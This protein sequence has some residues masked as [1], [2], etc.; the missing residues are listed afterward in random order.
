M[1]SPSV[2]RSALVFLGVLLTLAPPASAQVLPHARTYD[3][4]VC[5][6]DT[7]QLL[8]FIDTD[9]NGTITE[10]NGFQVAFDA[11]VAGSVALQSPCSIA[12]DRSG[13]QYTSD[14][15]ADLVMRTLDQ[16]GDGDA[17][18]AGEWSVFIDNSNL[19]GVLFSSAL[20]IRAD[21]QGG[22]VGINSSGGSQP[23]D[24]V[25][26]AFDI[27]QDGDAMDLAE[28]TIVYDSVAGA[29]N[30]AV[31]FGLCVEPS[32]G[33]LLVAD[34][35]P[36]VVYRL[37]DANSDGDYY[38]AG[39]ATIA[40]NSPVGSP[41]IKN[42]NTVQFAPDGALFLNDATS[43]FILRGVDGNADGDWNDVG[44]MAIFADKTG[45]T[46]GVPANHFGIEIDE[47]GRVFAVEN[48]TT[49]GDLVVRYADLNGD[50]DAQDAGEVI[51]VYE[52]GVGPGTVSTLRNIALVPAPR[53]E[54][55]AGTSTSS[56][57]LLQLEVH[58]F[59]SQPYQLLFGFVPLGM[60]ASVAPYG[61]LSYVPFA[62]LW[63]ASIP[64]G[65]IDS[66]SFSIPAGL[67]TPFTIHFSAAV[68]G[69]FRTYL[70]NE[71][72]ISF[73]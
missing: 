68:G 56:P 34:V 41:A 14:F 55:P 63:S 32:T 4:A 35:N 18:D 9:Q 36:D 71:Q 27:N 24:F 42:V 64:V 8:R 53:L 46:I 52:G 59:E 13:W 20:V 30:I 22:I 54:A 60:N 58:G 51:K 21:A 61:Y 48:S 62:T 2:A 49:V 15:S 33:D 44:E 45:N 28:I 7:T 29:F 72:S 5:D 11:A 1:R 3:I 39:E 17:N 73:Q 67:P 50:L 6:S 65:G 66:L 26:R 10:P 25:W 31:P 70:T 19:S 23:L 57:G 37:H 40:Y 16:N 47:H 43:D 69:P 12:F 38:D